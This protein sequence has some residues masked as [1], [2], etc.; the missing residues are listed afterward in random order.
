M[1]G[2]KVVMKLL[3]VYTTKESNYITTDRKKFF[4]TYLVYYGIWLVYCSLVAHN[5]NLA[6]VALPALLI[7]VLPIALQYNA[8]K[9]FGYSTVLYIVLNVIASVGLF[10]LGYFINALLRGAL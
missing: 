2:R 10:G 3:H 1:K 9:S 4:S 8:W 5:L 6:L 7:I